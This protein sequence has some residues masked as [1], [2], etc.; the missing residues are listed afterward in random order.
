MANIEAKTI[1]D[2]ADVK[3]RVATVTGTRIE[4]SYDLPPGMTERHASVGDGAQSF[5][6]EYAYPH[7]RDIRVKGEDIAKGIRDAQDWF[8]TT[9][10]KAF[11]DN[12][13]ADSLAWVVEPEAA[14]QLCGDGRFKVKAYM[15]FALENLAMNAHVDAELA[16]IA[17]RDNRLPRP[18]P[19]DFSVPISLEGDVIVGRLGGFELGVQF[20]PG[21]TTSD[22]INAMNS[23][24]QSIYLGME[25]ERLGVHVEKESDHG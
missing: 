8:R 24:N 1:I 3:A 23:I 19:K 21:K 6:V 18:M 7:P 10:A 2:D 25:W 16:K 11:T 13:K 14:I 22:L 15:R 4:L 17:A 5:A 12:P 20:V 9:M